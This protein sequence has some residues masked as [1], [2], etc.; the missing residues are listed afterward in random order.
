M[1]WKEVYEYYSRRDV[2]KAILESSKDREVAV[3]V[4]ESFS[5]RPDILQFPA[6]VKD[7]A[8]KGA[9]SFHISEERW[10]DPMTL[11]TGLVKKQM[12]DLRIGWDLIIDIDTPS[13][14]YASRTAYFVIEALKFHNIECIGVKFSGNKGWHI[15][16]PFEAF[17]DEVNSVNIKDLFPDAPK[18]IIEYLKYMIKPFL[19]DEMK[20]DPNIFEEIKQTGKQFKQEEM[21][22][23]PEVVKYRSKYDGSINEIRSHS[24]N[25]VFQGNTLHR[26][27][28][29]LNF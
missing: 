2:Q 17:P 4:G 9:T 7:W 5:K 14:K 25:R 12:D 26:I 6:D 11:Q 22:F 20:K 1:D 10:K 18:V 19:V 21:S 27:L 29:H 23:N 8:S 24:A 3:R 13:W 28:I 16:V 15:C